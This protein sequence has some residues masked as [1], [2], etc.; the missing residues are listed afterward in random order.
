MPVNS[1]CGAVGERRTTVVGATVHDPDHRW[2]AF[3]DALSATG[4]PAGDEGIAAFTQ[5]ASAEAGGMDHGE[6]V[7][8]V[9]VQYLHN[10]T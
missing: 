2:N 9:T 3:A 5:R 10:I 6:R 4:R 7:L 8:Y 1:E